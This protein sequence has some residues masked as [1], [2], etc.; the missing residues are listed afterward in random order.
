VLP[1]LPLGHLSSSGYTHLY[2]AIS[3]VSVNLMMHT[4]GA[5]RPFRHDWHFSEASSFQIGVSRGLRIA[6]NGKLARVSQRCISISSQPSPPLRH[7][8]GRRWL[9]RP[10]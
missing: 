5:S 10:P 7:C 1:P 9:C 2:G 8:N 6:S 4:G 3:R